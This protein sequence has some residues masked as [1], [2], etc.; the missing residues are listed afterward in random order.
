MIWGC[1]GKVS[2]VGSVEFGFRAS[3]VW[4]VVWLQGLGLALGGLGLGSG[5]GQCR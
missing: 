3:W 5:T 2:A 4:A 1:G